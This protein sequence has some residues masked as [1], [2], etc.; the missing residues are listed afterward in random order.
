[1]NS[2]N[3]KYKVIFLDIDGVLNVDYHERDKYGNLFHP[4]FVNNLKR[5]IKETGA[6]IV[7]SSSWRFSGF[8]VMREMWKDRNLPG[9]VIGI[10]DSL[11]RNDDLS[12]YE[13]LERGYEIQDYLNNHP[14]IINY[15]II[16]DDSDM[17]ESQMSHFVKTSENHNHPDCIDI[18][19]GLT[20]ICTDNAIE[21]LNKK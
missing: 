2:N 16:D 15:V 5:I 1:M 20:N 9:E 4:H 11:N 17:L 8:I 14:N 3:E 18:G 21:I 19:Y 7:I 6:K 12:F 10:T 13:R